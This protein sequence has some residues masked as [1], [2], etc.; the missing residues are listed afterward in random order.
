MFKTLL[1][2]LLTQKMRP[3]KYDYRGK[4]NRQLLV[5]IIVGISVLPL[6]ALL[7]F[8]I[9]S[10]GVMMKASPELVT[11]GY[12][13]LITGTQ[14]VVLFTGIIS[15]L[16][17]IYFSKDTEY[18]LPLPVSPAKIYAAKLTVVYIEELI[19]SAVMSL[20]VIVPYAVGSGAGINT[21]LQIPLVIIIA[22][23]LPLLL[24]AV[25]AIPLMWFIGFF[26]NK[27]A[28]T[29]IVYIL[30]FGLLYGLYFYFILSFQ[31]NAGEGEIGDALARLI[32]AISESAKFIFPNYLLAT[33]LNPAGFGDY[34]TSLLL[35]LLINAALLGI[36]VL[37]S[38]FVYRST[39]SKQLETP[40][41]VIK[42]PS[43]E[44][45]SGVLGS[46]IK[47]DLRRIIRD[48]G[49]GTYTLM[50]LVIVPILTVFMV[51]QFSQN[52]SDGQLAIA[53]PLVPIFVT[54]LTA[55]MGLST[56]Y[57]ATSA[58]TRENRSFY[59]YKM[60][61]VDFRKVM[62]SKII[63][64]ALF[65]QMT[66]ILTLA[67]TAIFVSVDWLSIVAMFLLLTALSIGTVSWQAYL[68]LSKPRLNWNTFSE[69]AKNNPA[70]LF[71]MLLGFVLL[72]I[73]GGA[74]V[75][76]LYPVFTGAALAPWRQPVMWA[77]L[78]AISVAYMIIS[79]EITIANCQKLF[80][81]IEP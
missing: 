39:I 25:I 9:Y 30:L 36:A 24:G 8:S 35:A 70:S 50:Q 68:D 28:T 55:F 3:Q 29:S 64:G 67:A 4:K 15:M 10:V 62:K 20:L 11:A 77:I 52:P 61:P 22:P 75:A 81:R 51:W 16:S 79:Y 32:A 18:L 31:S 57:A 80:D 56:N 49:I 40:K 59:V 60:L 26:K 1:K 73:I 41:I 63:I 58:F 48:T 2:T 7:I 17:V 34:I 5:L 47:S 12:T 13:Y 69:G 76:F 42:G 71:S 21:Y 37:V 14:L 53:L 66:I 38:S 45:S 54:A 6:A 44:K 74:G 72:L 65:N 27:G 23:M 43:E 46:L 19:T 33:T 78:L